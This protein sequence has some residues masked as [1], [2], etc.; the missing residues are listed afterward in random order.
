MERVGV[1]IKSLKCYYQVS[2]GDSKFCLKT[3][4]SLRKHKISFTETVTIFADDLASLIE[5]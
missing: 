5:D 4:G 1:T 3:A 2:G